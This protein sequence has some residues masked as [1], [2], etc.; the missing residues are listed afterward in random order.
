MPSLPPNIILSF[1]I[2]HD[3]DAP[4]FRTSYLFLFALGNLPFHMKR[5]DGAWAERAAG[6]VGRTKCLLNDAKPA[7]HVIPLSIVLSGGD[8]TGA[9]KST[10]NYFG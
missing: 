1:H 5:C 2:H 3:H 7:L 6:T 9:A 10:N 8:D 4:L